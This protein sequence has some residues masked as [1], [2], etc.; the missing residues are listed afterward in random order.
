MNTYGAG[1]P[2][3]FRFGGGRRSHEEQIEARH[4][5]SL[6]SFGALRR[7]NTPTAACL[8]VLSGVLALQSESVMFS[9]LRMNRSRLSEAPNRTPST[10]R[11]G[12]L[13]YAKGVTDRWQRREGYKCKK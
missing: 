10:L 12:L 13:L 8:V 9:G 11:M 2:G 7:D 1:G 5:S 6:P 4:T 3:P